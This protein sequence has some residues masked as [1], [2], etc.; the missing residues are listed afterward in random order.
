M[1]KVEQAEVDPV[2]I[3][4]SRQFLFV[5]ALA[6][7]VGV[8]ASFVAWVFLE[9][10]HELQKGAFT[11]LPKVL[12]YDSAPLWW[13]LPILLVAGLMVA[14]AVARMPG[15]GGHV[16]A[17]GLDPSPTR[18]NAVPGVAAAALGGLGLGAVLGPEA[19]LIAIGGALG[20]MAIRI[21]RKD[22]P[23]QVSDLIASSGT[24]A[25]VSFLFGSPLIAAV[26][27]IEAAGIGGA[28]LP[29]VLIPGLLAAGIG[30]LISI[31]MGSWTGVSTDD[32]SLDLLKLPEFPRPD[33]V[34]FLWTI[35]L[36]IAIALGVWVIFRLARSVERVATPRPFLV[37]PAA[38]LLI[39]GLAIAFEETTDMGA[40]QVLFS[41]QEA[42]GPLVAN[43]EAWS[44]GALALLLAFKGAAYSVALGTFRGGPVF[45]AMLLA[46]VAGVMA[47]DLPGM[48]LTPAVAIGL[49]A[50]VT[51]TLRLP[52]SGVVL[53]VLLT[54][55][56]GLGAGPL[57]ILGVV[58]AYLTT[59]ALPDREP[60]EAG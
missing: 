20:F 8:V 34:D 53:A 14:F 37:I 7:A 12:G 41:G 42:I 46:A 40:D 9:A 44:L 32:I 60:A 15:R 36:A 56:G 25:A 11:E 35:P 21:V 50:A 48:D 19:P 13:P 45:P 55:S 6:A 16:P 10:I 59:L 1:D 52:L 47:A 33:L 38:G 23:T 18:P 22:A 4:R 26:V 17:H 57:I 24:F 2:A 31:G 3:M 54:S 27:L 5:L 30:S 51:A 58:V 28:M 43:P 39:A 29:L 49:G